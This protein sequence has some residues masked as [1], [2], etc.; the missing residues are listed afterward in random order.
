MAVPAAR[1]RDDLESTARARGGRQTSSCQRPIRCKPDGIA[2]PRIF[3]A[4]LIKHPGHP[5]ERIPL[6]QR[7][8]YA[9]GFVVQ[10]LLAGALRLQP[11]L[12]Q[13]HDA[14]GAWLP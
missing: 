7:G 14:V 10:M 4:D 3:G 1:V 9:D 2:A 11:W 12:S 5:R 6:K 8:H 13:G